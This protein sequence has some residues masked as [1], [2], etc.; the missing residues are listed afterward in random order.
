MSRRREKRLVANNFGL[1]INDGLEVLSNKDIATN[2]MRHSARHGSHAVQLRA[3]NPLDY[4]Q[5]SI[6]T[7][8]VTK[9]FILRSKLSRFEILTASALPPIAKRKRCR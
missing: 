1:L 4:I 6:V 2:Q 5:D 7:R 3:N 8:D 9:H